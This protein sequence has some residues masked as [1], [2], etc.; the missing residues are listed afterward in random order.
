[1]SQGLTR[2][3]TQEDGSIDKEA[4]KAMFMTSKYLDWTRFAE[5]QGWDALFIRRQLPVKSW[6]KEKRDHLADRKMDILSG[7]VHERK[8][9]WTEDILKTLDEYPAAID[10]ALN[11]AKGKLMQMADMFKDYHDNFRNKPEQMYRTTKAGRKIRVFHPFERMDAGQ[12]G[13]ILG[14]MKSVTDAKL[15]ALML[16]KWA[17]SKLDLPLDIE[18]GEEGTGIG[19]RFTI[20]GK[21]DLD[22]EDLQR[23]FDLYH[24]KQLPAAA[25]PPPSNEG[26]KIEPGENGGS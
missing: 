18:E 6:I 23:W 22:A 8:F 11:V 3:P 20:E 15:K 2:L 26:A 21:S 13:S 17:I 7:L 24:D 9:K 10:M 4:V 5:D 19:P 16:D 1:M 12:I 25:S 14:G